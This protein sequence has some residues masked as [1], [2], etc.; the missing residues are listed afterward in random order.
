LPRSKEPHFFDS[1][2]SW[3]QGIETYLKRYYRHAES[4]LTRGDA[5]PGYFHCYQK[6]IPRMLEIYKD[7]PPKFILI[8]RDPVKRAWFHYLHR[9][10]NGVE[11]EAFERALAL[12]EERLQENPNLWARGAVEKLHHLKC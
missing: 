12:E 3:N 4:Y 10:R 7:Q 5:T 8:F 2:A 6:A 9:V 11:K 1:D